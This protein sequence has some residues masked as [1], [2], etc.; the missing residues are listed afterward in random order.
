MN[1]HRLAFA[2]I[3]CFA[4]LFNMLAMPMTGAMAQAASSPAEQL[5]W[6]SF[7]TGSGTKMV[8]INIGAPEQ[9]A[10]SNDSHSNMQHCWCCSGSAP[11]VALPGHAPQLYFARYESN[12][13]V[14]PP[15]LQ[16]PTPRQQWPSLN[17]RAS[18]LV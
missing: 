3:A 5:L 2:W 15:S 10:P 1:R 11:L 18:P 16:P 6:S 14:A 17:P 7:C 4:V 13:S 9:K 8:A 12:R